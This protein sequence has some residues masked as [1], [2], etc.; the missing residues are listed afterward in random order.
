MTLARVLIVV[1]MQEKAPFL[2][3]TTE[4]RGSFRYIVMDRIAALGPDD[5]VVYV[6]MERGSRLSGPIS[7]QQAQDPVLFKQPLLTCFDGSPPVDN[8]YVK[9]AWDGAKNESLVRHLEGLSEGCGIRIFELVGAYGECCVAS[10]L[11]GLRAR[12][13]HVAIEVN[14]RCTKFLSEYYLGKQGGRRLGSCILH[15]RTRKTRHVP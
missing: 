1:D 13:P 10:T 4:K 15:A 6:I 9:R 12:F 7:V 2:R 8:V 5:E 14:E 11:N 3:M